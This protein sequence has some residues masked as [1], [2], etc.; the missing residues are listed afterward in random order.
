MCFSSEGVL[1][2]QSIQTLVSKKHILSSTPIENSQIQPSSIDLRLGYRAWRLQASFLPGTNS[3]VGERLEDLAMHEIDLSQGCIF[4]KNC[5][6]LVLLKESANLPSGI[7]AFANTKSSIGR[8]DLLTRLITDYGAEFDR[9]SESYKGPLYAEVSPRSFSVLV[10]TGMRLNQIRFR[11]GNAPTPTLIGKGLPEN[12]TFSSLHGDPTSGI[13]FSIDLKPRKG[14]SIGFKAKS[15]TPLIDLDRVNYYRVSDFWDRIEPESDRLILDPGAF[16]ILMSKETVVVPPQYA[17]EM[18]PYMAMMG[19]FRVHYAG[20]FDP[21]FGYEA[22][23]GKGSR[24]VLEVRCHE[25]PFTLQDGQ[26][27]GR[28]IYERM[29]EEPKILYGSKL[30]SNYQGQKLRLSKHFCHENA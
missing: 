20:F 4:E 27:I 9:V 7:T 26:V 18:A 30:N 10:R 28:L 13:N 15:H 8:L 17:A 29:A 21:G 23:G 14:Q 24:G 16:Y 6:Y 22:E 12:I 19:E 11:N 5:V 25:A 3:T 1:P 2:Y